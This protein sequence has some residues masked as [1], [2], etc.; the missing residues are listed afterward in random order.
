MSN[1]LNKTN[2][3]YCIRKS[4]ISHINT[5][6]IPKSLSGLL[7]CWGNFNLQIKLF[8]FNEQQQNYLDLNY[9]Q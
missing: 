4:N 9:S 2:Y 7:L 5:V 6:E 1:K 3:A 8:N